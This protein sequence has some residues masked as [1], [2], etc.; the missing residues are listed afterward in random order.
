MNKVVRSV[1][2]SAGVA[3]FL[4]AAPTWS[5][6]EAPRFVNPDQ[7]FALDKIPT[8]NIAPAKLEKLRSSLKHG[9]EKFQAGDFEQSVK[10]YESAATLEPNNKSITEAL[11]TARLMAESQ[12]KLQAEIP[13][14]QRE[15]Q[16]FLENAYS[17][18]M[19]NYKK[20]RYDLAQQSFQKLWMT[21]GDFKGQTLKMYRKA[22]ESQ[23]K[24][25]R[26]ARRAASGRRRA[27]G[28]AGRG[29]RD[30]TRCGNRSGRRGRCH[31]KAGP[32]GVDHTLHRSD[33]AGRA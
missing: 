5:G 3:I 24:G 11:E 6:A 7:G 10:W 18:A 13:A 26:G 29:S 23:R 22:A 9:A 20:E 4:L 16:R 8:E 14:A 1:W 25:R 31:L 21:A 2:Q 28:P 30:R 15:R 32:S 19:A 17:E 27:G 12:K 33:Q